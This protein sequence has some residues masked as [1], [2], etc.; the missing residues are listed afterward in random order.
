M[1]HWVASWG[2]VVLHWGPLCTVLLLSQY[3][4]LHC[5]ALCWSLLYCTF[6]YCSVIPSNML[7]CTVMHCT[8]LHSRMYCV[9]LYTVLC[10]LGCI[11]PNMH[12][13]KSPI[14]DNGAKL[15][16]T[17]YY[18]LQNHTAESTALCITVQCSA[19]QCPVMQCSVVQC[20]EI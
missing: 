2:A 16:E 6:L 8:A 9:W 5:T 19:V 20:G 13:L 14:S 7:N 11:T 1:W 4:L 15:P 3:T 17:T 18:T 10:T 12:C